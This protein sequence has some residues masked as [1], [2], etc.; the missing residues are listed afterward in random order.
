[1]QVQFEITTAAEALQAADILAGIAD[2]FG[3]EV[4]PRDTSKPRRPRR[5][6]AATTALTPAADLAAGYNAIAA[7][8]GAATIPVAES[9][10]ESAKTES[11]ETVTRDVSADIAAAA[12]LNAAPVVTSPPAVV[13]E[14]AAPVSKPRAEVEAETRSL[15]VTLGVVW[16]RENVI[17]KYGKAKLSEVTDEQLAEIHANA[18]AEVARRAS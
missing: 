11:A 1:M 17:Q 13:T 15:A 8:T 14:P 12:A 16:L 6:A 5:T 3:D 18:T 9:Q 4:S 10:P 2:A 7:A